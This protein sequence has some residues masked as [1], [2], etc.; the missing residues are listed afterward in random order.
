MSVANLQASIQELNNMSP[1]RNMRKEWIIKDIGWKVFAM[2]MAID[3]YI[4]WLSLRDYFP[5][6]FSVRNALQPAR[7]DKIKK[8]F[9]DV[10]ESQR[11]SLGST[12]R[13]SASGEIRAGQKSL[14]DGIKCGSHA[15][16][17][18]VQLCA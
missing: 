6:N 2:S 17:R 12:C 3:E 16:I 5:V 1:Q 11:T 14:L 8:V 7:Y 9:D 13:Y 18:D 15:S 4:M 10:Q